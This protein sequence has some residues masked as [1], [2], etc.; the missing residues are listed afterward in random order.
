M[1]PGICKP[2]RETDPNPC[3]AVGTK[4]TI[5]VVDDERPI[6]RLCKAMIANLGYS[7]KTAA[8]GTEALAV[9]AGSTVPIRLALLDMN[10][11]DM[12]LAEIVLGIRRIDGRIPIIVQSGA[13]MRR[14]DFTAEGLDICDCLHKPY[15]MRELSEKLGQALA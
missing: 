1:Q 8:S 15:S 3:W 9:V 5:L 4:G 7:V 10:L 11:P 12:T 13:L 14:D 2:K 6:V